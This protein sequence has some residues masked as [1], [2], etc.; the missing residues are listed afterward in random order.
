MAEDSF[1]SQ[2]CHSSVAATAIGAVLVLAGAAG[3]LLIGPEVG[4]AVAVYTVIQ[5]AGSIA[6]GGALVVANISRPFIDALPSGVT[7]S[8]WNAFNKNIKEAADIEQLLRGEIA[9]SIS[10]TPD[11]WLLAGDAADLIKVYAEVGARPLS[12][13]AAVHLL[14]TKSKI[15]L[16][17]I[18][19]LQKVI[20]SLE[21]QR[22]LQGTK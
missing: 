6:A 16:D 10:D 20:Q 7:Q 21:A 1:V 8:Q 11:A 15:T 12:P 22:K 17:A 4:V 2:D 19:H 3:L 14:S 13:A 5:S 18:E 9:K